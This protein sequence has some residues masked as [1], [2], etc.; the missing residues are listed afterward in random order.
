MLQPVL[1]TVVFTVLFGRLAKFPSQGAPYEV[2]IFAALLP[3]QFFANTLGGKQ[4]LDGGLRAHH[5]TGL[6]SRG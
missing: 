6:F 1:T 3:W 5:F 2:I 4:Q